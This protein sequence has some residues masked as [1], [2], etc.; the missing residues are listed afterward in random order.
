MKNF[1]SVVFLVFYNNKMSNA[2]KTILPMT[3]EHD[4][5]K[6]IK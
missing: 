6:K 4:S 1:F 3:A 2:D 5:E